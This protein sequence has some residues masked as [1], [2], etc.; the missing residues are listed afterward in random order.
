MGQVVEEQGSLVSVVD[1][2]AAPVSAS[3]VVY[4]EVDAGGA[5]R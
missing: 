1:D 3:P 5:M 2:D 4:S